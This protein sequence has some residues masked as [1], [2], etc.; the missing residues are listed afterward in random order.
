M[1]RGP[2]GTS[3]DEADNTYH[4]FAWHENIMKMAVRIVILGSLALAAVGKYAV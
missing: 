2:A 4:R 3:G 1:A